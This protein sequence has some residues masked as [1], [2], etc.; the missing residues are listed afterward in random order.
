MSCFNLVVGPIGKSKYR[1][2][3][4]LTSTNSC[5]STV[6]NSERSSEGGQV[7]E[8]LGVRER[9]D[10][11]CGLLLDCT[12]HVMFDYYAWALYPLGV[13]TV[14]LSFLV[15]G[16]LGHIDATDIS[17]LPQ[18]GEYV[19]HIFNPVIESFYGARQGQVIPRSRFDSE[20]DSAL[21]SDELLLWQYRQCVLLN[22]RGVAIPE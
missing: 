19:V 11:S 1:L 9:Y 7:W 8:E 3:R 18:G 6:S 4:C 10:A 12:L 22:L 20:D 15:F 2:P 17:R 21:P 5:H 14:G 16:V 13:S